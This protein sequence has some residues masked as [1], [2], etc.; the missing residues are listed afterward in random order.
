MTY[1]ALNNNNNNNS[2]WG[3]SSFIQLLQLIIV[4]SSIVISSAWYLST[5]ASD[6]K[7][8]SKQNDL[9]L[10][11][12]EKNQKDF[13]K[14]AS[15]AVSHDKAIAVSENEVKHIS[16]KITSIEDVIEKLESKKK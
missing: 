4:V 8:L 13:N 3:K 6:I 16:E 10:S 11:S 15:M 5:M 9:I 2:S 14:I 1:P 12:M 7:S